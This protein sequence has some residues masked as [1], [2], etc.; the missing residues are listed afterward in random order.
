MMVMLLVVLCRCCMFFRGGRNIQKYIA[1][2]VLHR[3]HHKRF[4]PHN[5]SPSNEIK[6]WNRMNESI[7]N[8]NDK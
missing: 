1:R 7:L 5:R 3:D 6:A 2:R 4:P 8:A